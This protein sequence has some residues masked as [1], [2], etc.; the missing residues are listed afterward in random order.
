MRRQTVFPITGGM[1]CLLAATVAAGAQSGSVAPPAGP[2]LAPRSHGFMLYLSQPLGGGGGPALHPK[3]GLRIDQV[4]MTGNSGAPDAG[5]PLQRR[6]LV[7]W[8]MGGGSGVHASDVKLE[9]GGRLTYDVTHGGFAAQLS[10]PGIPSNS[11]HPVSA[12][13]VSEPKSFELHGMEFRGA[14]V[15]SSEENARLFTHDLF[16]EAHGANESSSVFHEVAAAAIA[17]FKSSHSAPIQQRS[18]PGERPF[19]MQEAAR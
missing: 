15:H 7:G 12:A 9:L 14:E 5:D 2:A 18:R 3:F 16:H 1:L 11:S 19:A 4:R 17:T 8:Q 10:R 6:S 13:T